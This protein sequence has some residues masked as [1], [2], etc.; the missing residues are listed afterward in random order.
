[1]GDE[2]PWEN[3]QLLEELYWDEE[4]NLAEIGDEL[5]CSGSTIRQKMNWFDIPRRSV[6]EA[7]KVADYSPKENEPWHDGGRLHQLYWE[8]EMTV[9]EVGEELGCEAST[10]VKWM[11]RFGISRREAHEVL[12]PDH[13]ELYDEEHLVSL[14]VEDGLGVNEIADKI[15]CEPSSVRKRLNWYGVEFN[16]D[17]NCPQLYD[18]EW[19]VESY[20]EDWNS[21]VEIS[22]EIGCHPKRVRLALERFDI[23]LRTHSDRPAIY[24]TGSGGHPKWL[25]GGSEELNSIPVHR[26]LAICE[27]GFEEVQGMHVHHKNGVK[28]DNR[29]DNIE[30]MTPSEH[31]R[32]HAKLPY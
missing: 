22:E 18:E 20:L 9:V 6:A 13:P 24:I 4:M 16:P 21:V 15:G 27:Y 31:A 3:K 30:V 7:K 1:M 26:L 29:P 17:S 5:G 12:K 28:W 11:E 23:E 25:C 10:V 14:F 2:K 19:M 32:E 8:E